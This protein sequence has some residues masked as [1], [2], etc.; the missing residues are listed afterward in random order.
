MFINQY[1]HKLLNFAK[2]ST[3]ESAKKD[4]NNALSTLNYF[5][6]WSDTPGF[7]RL[8]FYLDWKKYLF[9]FIKVNLKYFFLVGK[10]KEKIILPR[11]K[12][13]YSDYKKVILTWCTKNQFDTNGNYKDRYFNISAK[14]KNSYLWLLISIDN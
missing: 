13:N 2:K 14:E 11:N 9:Y 6:T 12:Q 10:F 4:I 3:L 7:T 8:K 1:V 5:V